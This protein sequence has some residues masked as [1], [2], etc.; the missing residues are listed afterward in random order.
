M[1]DAGATAAAAVAYCL[2]GCDREEIQ[3][4]QIRGCLDDP[5]QIQH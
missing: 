3:S 1:S 4:E 5:I 2:L